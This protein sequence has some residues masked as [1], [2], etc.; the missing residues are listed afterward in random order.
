MKLLNVFRKKER[1]SIRK[2]VFPCTQENNVSKV[3]DA[4][5]YMGVQRSEYVIAIGRKSDFN[6]IEN[7]YATGI[8]KLSEI[9]VNEKS[10]GPYFIEL[11]MSDDEDDW[12]KLE[13]SLLRLKNKNVHIIM[14]DY[15]NL[16]PRRFRTHLQSSCANHNVTVA[17]SVSQGITHNYDSYR[18]AHFE[19]VTPP[20][21]EVEDS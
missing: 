10:E 5:I 19:S 18:D 2:R 15:P 12:E 8:H 17:V 11:D 4:A 6:N 3:M 9:E 16:I 7:Q 20:V 13:S 21:F 1:K 14:Y